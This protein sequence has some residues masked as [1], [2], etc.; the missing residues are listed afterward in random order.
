MSFVVFTVEDFFAT[1]LDFFFDAVF[2]AVGVFSF[3]GDE[4]S[5]IFADVFFK[6]SFSLPL[7]FNNDE[8]SSVFFIS[9][10]PL[11]CFSVLCLETAAQSF[12]LVL[13][14]T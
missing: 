9:A 2:F 7:P 4:E 14:P 13:L 11:K 12:L 5:I 8:T 1:G 6:A 3:S 10:L